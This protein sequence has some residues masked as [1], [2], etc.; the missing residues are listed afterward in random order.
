MAQQ[1]TLIRW[2]CGN[3]NWLDGG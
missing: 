2:C 1:L 3:V